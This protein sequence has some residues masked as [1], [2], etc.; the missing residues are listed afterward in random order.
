MSAN[1]L[2]LVTHVLQIEHGWNGAMVTSEAR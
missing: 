1:V 2:D